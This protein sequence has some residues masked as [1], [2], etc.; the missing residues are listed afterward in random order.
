MVSASLSLSLSRVSDFL[1]FPT[2]ASRD[3]I[4]IKSPALTDCPDLDQGVDPFIRELGL[5][6]QSHRSFIDAWITLQHSEAIMNFPSDVKIREK[7]IPTY[8]LFSVL[9]WDIRWDICNVLSVP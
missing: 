3:P 5:A 7:C 8:L 4:G 1:P 6:Y 9:Y 2:L